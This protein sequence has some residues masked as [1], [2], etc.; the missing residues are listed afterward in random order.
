MIILVRVVEEMG[1]KKK[2][3]LCIAVSLVVFET[4]AKDVR[5]DDVR[6]ERPIVDIR[7]DVR[8]GIRNKKSSA[9]M[10]KNLGLM[11]YLKGSSENQKN[12]NGKI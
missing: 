7:D 4:T 3:F 9:N 11:D 8:G 5:S 2:L 10:K 6:S 12:K 1:M